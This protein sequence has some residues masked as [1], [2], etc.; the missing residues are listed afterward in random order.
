ML[1]RMIANYTEHHPG[2][3]INGVPVQ[4]AIE[5]YANYQEYREYYLYVDKNE[6]KSLA[7]ILGAVVLRINI[8]IVCVELRDSNDVS[9]LLRSSCVE[10]RLCEPMQV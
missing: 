7:L 8:D 2:L 1:R 3:S 6:G 5:E 10:C 4:T 9:F